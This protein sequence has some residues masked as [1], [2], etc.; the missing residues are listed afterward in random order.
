MQ[1]E[2][3][4]SH[5][6][7]HEFIGKRHPGEL[8]EVMSAIEACDAVVCLAKITEEPTKPSL[9]FS[10]VMFNDSIQQSLHRY[11]WTEASPKSKKG[12]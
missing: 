8:Q 6:G 7:G 9:L 4:Y 1:I 11:G 10:P 5:K 12:F 2:Q 3:Q